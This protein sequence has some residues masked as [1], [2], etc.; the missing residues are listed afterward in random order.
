VKNDH[1]LV[2]DDMYLLG[3]GP[4]SAQAARELAQAARK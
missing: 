2:F 3:L 4:R 1:L